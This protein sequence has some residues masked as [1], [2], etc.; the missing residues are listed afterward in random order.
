MRPL[1]FIVVLPE[2]QAVVALTANIGDM[3]AELNLVWEYLLPALK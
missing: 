1:T 2:Q 3:Q